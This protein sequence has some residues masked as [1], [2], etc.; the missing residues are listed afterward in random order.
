[1]SKQSTHDFVAFYAHMAPDDEELQDVCSDEDGFQVL[2]EFEDGRVRTFRN[3][4]WRSFDRVVHVVSSA[5]VSDESWWFHHAMQQHRDSWH[6]GRRPDEAETF[7]WIR[8]LGALDADNPHVLRTWPCNRRCDDWIHNLGHTIPTLSALNGLVARLPSRARCISVGS[9]HALWEHLLTLR[10]FRVDCTE[11]LPWNSPYALCERAPQ[12]ADQIAWHAGRW[13]VLLLVWPE[14]ACDYDWR[15]LRGFRGRLLVWIGETADMP[16]QSGYTSTSKFWQLIRR[17]RWRVHWQ[18][19]LP[20]LPSENV[21][22]RLVL[23]GRRK[24][25]FEQWT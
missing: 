19:A 4:N 1:M 6:Q 15:A 13:S 2:M 7:A 16:S 8:S 24:R 17:R 14:P 20:C 21:H 10:G 12:K 22:P 9:G 3:F 25:P 11:P 5:Q 23:F 18:R